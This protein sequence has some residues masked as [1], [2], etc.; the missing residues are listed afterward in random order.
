[1]QRSSMR[2]YNDVLTNMQDSFAQSPAQNRIKLS[3]NNS[4]TEY[5]LNKNSIHFN[6]SAKF[7]TCLQNH[8]FLSCPT[9]SVNVSVIQQ[10]LKSFSIST[11]H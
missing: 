3:E 11:H 9:I 10:Y 8:S 6:S 1:M 5:R 7:M 2:T 4:V